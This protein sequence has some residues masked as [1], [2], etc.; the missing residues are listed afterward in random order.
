MTLIK[1][2]VDLRQRQA[3]VVFDSAFSLRGKADEGYPAYTMRRIPVNGNGT[4]QQMMS[5]IKRPQCSRK[6]VGG[7]MASAC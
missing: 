6:A 5:E 1:V 3:A 4:P 2:R 7:R